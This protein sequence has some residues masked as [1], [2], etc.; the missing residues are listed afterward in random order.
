MG[1]AQTDSNKLVQQHAY[2]LCHTPTKHNITAIADTG[3]SG[4]YI[5]TTNPYNTDGTTKSPVIVGLPN[6][7]SLR[8]NNKIC[9]LALPQLPKA[10]RDAHILPGLTHSSLISIG[11]L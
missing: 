2:Q 9:R 10:A 11:K 3:A 8:S 5:R 1:D 4:H 7:A 6:G